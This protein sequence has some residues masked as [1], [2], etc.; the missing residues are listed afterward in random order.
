MAQNFDGY[1]NLKYL[2]GKIL[3]DCPGATNGVSVTVHGMP[4]SR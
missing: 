1:I 4:Y 2:M 3:M